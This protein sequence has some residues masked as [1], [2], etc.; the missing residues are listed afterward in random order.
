M[1]IRLIRQSVDSEFLQ[2]NE[3]RLVVDIP[4][5]LTVDRDAISSLCFLYFYL[6]FMIR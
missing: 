4:F 6:D 1:L 2:E 3:C 5:G